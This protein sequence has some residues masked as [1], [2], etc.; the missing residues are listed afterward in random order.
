M[1]SIIQEIITLDDPYHWLGF[2]FVMNDSTKNITCKI[3]NFSKCCETFGIN[4]KIYSN[5]SK[6]DDFIGAEYKYIDISDITYDED[7]YMTTVTII[8]YTNKGTIVLCFYNQHNGYY[9]HDVFIQIGENI[10]RLSI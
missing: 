7:D 6:F 1:S 10:N 3:E 4:T 2:T 9:F 8:I 5:S